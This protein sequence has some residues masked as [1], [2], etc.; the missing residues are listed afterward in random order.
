MISKLSLAVPELSEFLPHK[1]IERNINEA[2]PDARPREIE[3][4]SVEK[5]LHDIESSARIIDGCQRRISQYQVEIHKKFSIPFSCIIFVLIG[6]PLAI[7]AG[8]KGMTT[9]IGFSIVFFLIYYMF[10]ISGEKFADRQY[11]PAWL[12]MWLPN[13][14]LFSAA[15]LLLWSTVRESQTINWKKL[16]PRKLWRKNNSTFIL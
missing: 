14:I 16:D 15:I 12:A 7:R 10:L 3:S 8:K 11:M 2:K 4:L 1:N 6:A 9:S 13:F 5:V